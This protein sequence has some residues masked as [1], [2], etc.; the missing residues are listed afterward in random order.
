MKE[1]VGP[2]DKKHE[3]MQDCMPMDLDH[4]SND[5]RPYNP[6]EGDDMAK[7]LNET[8]E[9]FLSRLPPSGTTVES[10]PWIWI[11]NPFSARRASQGDIGGF[12]DAGNELLEEYIRR[13]RA[14]E[15]Q[16]PE[17]APGTITRKLKADREWL[18][19]S[20]NKAAR[21]KG[22]TH[23][24]WMLFPSSN[25]VD[26]IWCSV[27]KGTLTGTLGCA[28]KVA[29]DDG[30]DKVRLIC[31]Y[32]EDCFD[33]KDVRRVLERLKDMHLVRSGKGEQG[34]YY[35]CDAYTHL[36]IMSGNVYNL[37]ASMYSSKELLSKR[38]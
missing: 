10:G 1:G 36:D 15:D 4:P 35:K 19:K 28:A 38:T 31:I 23:G 2:D 18:E 17:K 22:V 11:A 7:Q 20:I 16:N 5:Q 34:I 27:A 37:K 24:K 12:N 9:S 30:S 3:P 25:H 13:R 14:L 21:D 29:T 8:L 32:T 6:Y 26:E 33:Q